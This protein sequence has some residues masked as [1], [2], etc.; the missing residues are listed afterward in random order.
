MKPLLNGRPQGLA[1]TA[2]SQELQTK[3]CPPNRRPVK[4]QLSFRP[5][6]FGVKP[7]N[8]NL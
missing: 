4:L 2:L 3:P 1:A 8:H 7:Q 5:V 6:S